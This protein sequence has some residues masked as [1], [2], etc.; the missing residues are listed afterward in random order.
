MCNK[1]TFW[2]LLCEAI[3]RPHWATDVDFR[4]FADR[5]QHRERLTVMLDETLGERSTSEW[6]ERFAGRVPAAPVNSLAAALDNP[7]I[8]ERAMVWAVPHPER[9]DFRMLGSPVDAG[10]DAL[11]KQAAPPLGHDTDAILAECGFSAARIAALRR[12]CVI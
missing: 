9:A 3:G 11:P 10:A 4:S 12:A 5:L 2:P 6:L 7:F 1:E 8:G